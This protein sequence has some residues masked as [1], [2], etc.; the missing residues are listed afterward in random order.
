V[1]KPVLTRDDGT[2]APGGLKLIERMASE[3]KTQRSIAAALGLAYKKFERM[4]EANKGDNEVRYAW[5]RGFAVFEQ[6]T[7]D[8]FKGMAFG[9]IVETYELNDDGEKIPDEDDPSGFKK[10]RIQAPI[11]K[12]QTIAAIFFAKTQLGWNEKPSGP[13]VQENKINITLPAPMGFG[14]FMNALGQTDIIDARKD[15]TIPMKELL[16]EEV[17]LALA[18]PAKP[19]EE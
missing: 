16:P 14:E 7:V 12:A 19:P 9:D 6:D 8:K 5:E 3:H 1:T 10:V 18:A 4:L 17:R 11:S 15:K 2:I 13:M